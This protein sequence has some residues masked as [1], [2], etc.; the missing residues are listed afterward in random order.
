MENSELSGNAVE[1]KGSYALVAGI[2]LK[3]KELVGKSSMV[4]GG[5]QVPGAR[6]LAGGEE[7]VPGGGRRWGRAA[8]D[9]CGL[10]GRLCGCLVLAAYWPISVGL[11]VTL[12]RIPD[13]GETFLEI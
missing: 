3:I 4:G 2:L 7:Q 12:H 1:N 5:E 8:R 13:G 9:R 6:R 10:R 11:L